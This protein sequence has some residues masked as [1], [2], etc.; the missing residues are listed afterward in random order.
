[1]TSLQSLY[2]PPLLNH[3]FDAGRW[4]EAKEKFTRIFT[5]LSAYWSDSQEHILEVFYTLSA[6]FYHLAHVNGRAFSELAPSDAPLSGNG[7]GF[8]SVQQL[9][10]WAFGILERIIEDSRSEIES[11]R[12]MTVKQVQEYI[13]SHLG[14]DVSLQA[15]ADHI[16]L[17][18][19]YLSR[20]Y[21]LETGEGISDYL[22]RVRMERAAYLVKHS[23]LKIY[24]I[25]AQ[26]G[27]QNAPYFIKVFRKHYGMTPQE[28]RLSNN[29]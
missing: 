19:V 24:E 25:T 9:R 5:E 23:D 29:R 3:L 10:D 2:E 17:H 16:F 7:G 14:D 6:A 1:M 15:I 18:P 21:K 11:S 28:Y 13:E 8:R 20:L 26:L 27:Y 22:Y 4:D 12:V